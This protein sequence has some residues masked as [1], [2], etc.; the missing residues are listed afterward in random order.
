MIC[1]VSCWSPRASESLRV[2]N[3]LYIYI[4]LK[5]RPYHSIC[6]VTLVVGKMHPEETA[7]RVPRSLRAQ[8]AD[9]R[10]SYL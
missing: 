2:E 6:L 8:Q 7:D 4:Y 10:V 9:Q 5:S 3:K 1:Y